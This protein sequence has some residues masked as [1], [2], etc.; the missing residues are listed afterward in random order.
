[1]AHEVTET[2]ELNL[3]S[4]YLS[5]YLQIIINRKKVLIIT[6]KLLVVYNSINIIIL[7]AWWFSGQLSVV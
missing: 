7:G 1:M 6:I 2:L 3:V 4:F 5:M